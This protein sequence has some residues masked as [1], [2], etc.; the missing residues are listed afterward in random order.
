MEV[1]LNPNGNETW[2]WEEVNKYI[3][4]VCSPWLGF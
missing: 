2:N 1:A 4:K 3:K